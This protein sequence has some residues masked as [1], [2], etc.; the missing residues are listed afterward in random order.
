MQKEV[1]G[2][3]RAWRLYIWIKT[4]VAWL[5]TLNVPISFSERGWELHEVLLYDVAE[6]SD[7][8]DT[9]CG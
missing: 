8:V 4:W 6:P 9:G 1:E 2:P 5:A 7:N 3:R